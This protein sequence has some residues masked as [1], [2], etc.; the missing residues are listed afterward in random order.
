MVQLVVYFVKFILE[1]NTEIKVSKPTPEFQEKTG[2][3]LL[4][5]DSRML[6]ELLYGLQSKWSFLDTPY[7]KSLKFIKGKSS[8]P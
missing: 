4:G 6:A 2:C 3:L 5:Q 7:D 8:F 1:N